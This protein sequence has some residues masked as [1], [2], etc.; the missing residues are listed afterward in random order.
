VLQNNNKY[1]INRQFLYELD[2]DRDFKQYKEPTEKGKHLQQPKEG[3][4]IGP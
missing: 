2:L 4:S 3:G 1:D